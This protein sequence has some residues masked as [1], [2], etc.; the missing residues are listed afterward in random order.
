MRV[1]G[2]DYSN[3]QR[4][5]MRVFL[6]YASEQRD[7][8]QR[9]ALGLSNDGNHVFFDKDALPAGDSFDDRI[10][11]A[12]ARSHLFIFLISRASL[13][14]GAYARAELDM[15]QQRWPN[16]AGK[17][18]PVLGEDVAIEAL[19]PYLRAVSVL[20]TQGDLVAEVLQAAAWLARERRRGL[21]LRSLL[22]VASLL[23]VMAAGWGWRVSQRQLAVES[24][25]VTAV[26]QQSAAGAPE[27]RFD[28]TLRNRGAEAVTILDIGAHTDSDQA[29]FAGGST[30]WFDLDPKE[31]RALTFDAS[32]QGSAPA[33]PLRWRL[34]WGYVRTEDRV[35]ELDSE[36]LDVDLFMA[37]YRRDA[38]DGWR[39]WRPER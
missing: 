32:L 38:C 28:L 13:Q 26:S 20:E 24:V 6:S 34:C 4:P 31:R 14:K 23:A 2:S 36:K 8:A 7:L 5:C 12:I 10:R 17:V 35:Y 18:L 22:G 27:F 21:A 16:P 11:S 1:A 9:L 3:V 33:A 29:V 37:R 19:P 25:D 30:E 39:R 15:A